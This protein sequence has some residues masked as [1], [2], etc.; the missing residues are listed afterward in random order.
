MRGEAQA[1][2][3]FANREG[4]EHRV[5]KPPV[6][7]T[8]FIVLASSAFCFAQGGQAGL[9][10]GPYVVGLLTDGG[11]VCWQ[12]TAPAPG[13][14]RMK[15]ESD[16]NWVE[17]KEPKPAQFHAVKLSGLSPATVY[18]VEATS[19]GRKLGELTFRT[20]PAKE[21]TFT[22]YVYGDTR[23]HPDAHGQVVAAM[24]AEA[25]RLK[26]Y[27]FVV[28]TGDFAMQESKE[29]R[30][31]TVM[32]DEKV[33]ADEF[34]APAAPLL[35]RM[36]LV[37]VRGNHELFQDLFSKYFPAPEHPVSSAGGDDY[38]FDYGSVRLIVLDKYAPRSAMDARMKWM[39]ARLAE[40]ND[41]WRLVT[42]HEPIY[43]SGEHGSATQTRALLEPLLVAGKVHA[44]F[45]GHDHDYERTKPVQG[46]VHIVT[47]GGGAPLYDLT[48]EHT[49]DWS[50]KF[51]KTHNFVTVSVTPEKLTLTAFAPKDGGKD[52][53]VLDSV[54]IPKVC[55]WPAA[56]P[57]GVVGK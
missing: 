13:A 16:A 20:A 46:I 42:I 50:A 57:A 30:Q 7:L 34:F 5:R 27:T 24:M 2:E 25:A 26:Q 40:D 48:K 52:F 56:A 11:T 3:A 55:A 35:E 4:K 37:P 1:S 39:S 19:G 10:S 6:V 47:G 32:A 17:V 54:E 18:Q 15:A 12:T 23:S 9:L 45:A 8:A 51:V 29:F 41:R 21:D 28:H 44:V 53:A 33:T 36:P 14:V 49:G 38:C 31:A 43:S 22:F